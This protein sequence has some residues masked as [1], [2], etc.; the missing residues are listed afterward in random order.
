MLDYYHAV[1]HLA[2]FAEELPVKLRNQSRNGGQIFKREYT[3]YFQ[4][5]LGLTDYLNTRKRDIPIG[6]GALESAIRRVVNLRL[7]SADMFWKVENA[8]GFLH[9]RCQLK[10]GNWDR[11]YLGLLEIYAAT[12]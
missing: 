2:V 7:K 6:S 3:K 11:F 10:S 1:E 12:A 8:E 9:L 4:K 5:N